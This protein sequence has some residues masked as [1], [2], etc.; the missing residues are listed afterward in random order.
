[1]LANLY[2]GEAM[3]PWPIVAMDIIPAKLD[4]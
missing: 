1:M 4:R 2:P 3:N